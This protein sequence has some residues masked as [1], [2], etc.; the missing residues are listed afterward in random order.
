M[1]A[2]N[3]LGQWGEAIAMR[4]LDSKGYQLVSHDWSSYHK[5]ID[6]IAIHPSGVYVFVEVKTRTS[7]YERGTMLTAEKRYHLSRIISTYCQQHNVH[8]AQIDLIAIT[9]TPESYKIEHIEAVEC[10]SLSRTYHKPWRY[11]R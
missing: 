9:G 1:A 4:Y 5:D 3:E 7:S 10:P 8:R 11:R 6:I 2:H